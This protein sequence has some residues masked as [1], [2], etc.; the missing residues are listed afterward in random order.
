MFVTFV[1]SIRPEVVGRDEAGCADSD[2]KS[3]SNRGCEAG[4]KGGG[5][6]NELAWS[7]DCIDAA[8]S[9]VQAAL[10]KR[11]SRSGNESFGWTDH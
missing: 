4:E 11:L 6:V 1:F 8:N 9:H 5:F 2:S 10:K 3:R 7:I